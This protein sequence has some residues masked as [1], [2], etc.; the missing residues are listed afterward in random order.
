MRPDIETDV[1]VIG[2]GAGGSVVAYNLARAGER[3]TILERGKWVRPED[4]N[5][6]EIDMISLL[7]KDG[8]ALTNSEADMFLLQGNVVGGS[9]VLTNAVCFRLPQD[10]RQ[11]F[12]NQGFELP[13]DKLDAAFERCEGVLNVHDLEDDLYNPAAFRMM[14]GMRELGITPGRFK[15]GMLNCI[16]CGYCNVGCRY[17]RKLDASMTWV[18]MAVDHGAEVVPQSE[19]I[20]VEVKRGEVTGVI[21]RDLKDGAKFKVRAKRYVLAGGA[22]NT[23]ELLLKSKIMPDRVGR[24]TSFNAGAIVFAEYDEPVNGFDGDQMCVHHIT[25]KYAIEQVHNP[26]VSFALT[27]PGWFDRHHKDLMRYRNLTSAGV[28]VP[29]QPVGEVVLSFGRK[30]LRPLFDHADLKFEMPQEDMEVMRAGLKELIHIYLASGAKRVITPAHHYT[31]ITDESQL[32]LVDKHIRKQRDIVGF[33]SSHPQG[34]CPIGDDVK[35]DVVTPDFNVYGI[36]NLFVADASLFP[37][38]IRVNPMLSIMATA[39]LAAQK[40]GDITPPDAIEEGIAWEARR[41]TAAAAA[42]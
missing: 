26:P 8:G 38:S 15:K 4:M 20:K 6:N 22:I 32:D 21:C 36:E 10:I 24:R 39:D 18:P 19:A 25:D 23:P 31:E 12:A 5:E 30:V 3:V 35:R 1:L 41:Q 40:I 11:S 7:Y 9:T 42:P 2:S 29:T 14:D 33:G 16:G 34:G 17:G 27:M 28:L 13:D 37:H